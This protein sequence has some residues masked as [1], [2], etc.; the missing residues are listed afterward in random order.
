MGG[1]VRRIEIEIEK[2]SDRDTEE[3]HLGWTEGQ[4][5]TT[6]TFPSPTPP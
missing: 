4:T 6:D 1:P 3:V 5:G 2:D